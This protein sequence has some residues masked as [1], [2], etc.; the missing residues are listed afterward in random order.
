METVL[1]LLLEA[2]TGVTERE[3]W[4]GELLCCMVEN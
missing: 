2:E 3:R 1:G 4:E